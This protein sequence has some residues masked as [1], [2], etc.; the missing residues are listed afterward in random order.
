MNKT[1]SHYQALARLALQWICEPEDGTYYESLHPGTYSRV[2]DA[3]LLDFKHDA[4]K[5]IKCALHPAER[6]V[7]MLVHRDGMSPKE[8]V[9]VAKGRYPAWRPEGRV[10]EVV[11]RIETRVGL[12][13]EGADLGDVKKYF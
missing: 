8:A 10:E 4:E 6:I 11:E 5:I 2:F 7:L 9:S 13:L 3:A 1:D 12:A